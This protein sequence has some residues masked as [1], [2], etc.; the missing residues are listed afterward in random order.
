MGWQRKPEE[1]KNFYIVL[2]TGNF[3]PK[4]ESKFV[5]SYSTAWIELQG[6][7]DYCQ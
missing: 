2:V 3:P 4:Y 1:K 6:V 5:K 7:L